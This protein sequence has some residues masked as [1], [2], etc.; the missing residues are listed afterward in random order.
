[1]NWKVLAAGAAVIVPLVGVLAM[2]FGSD[3]RAIPSMLE[4]RPAPDFAL[5]SMDGQ[6]FALDDFS[7]KPLVV[8]FWASWC[9]PC[10]QEHPWLVRTAGQYQPRGVA[11]LGVLYGD[12]V[13][14]A[15]GFLARYGNA[16]PTLLDPSQRVAIDYGVAGVP[17][18]FVIDGQGNIVK[19]FTG[20]VNPDELLATL[21]ALL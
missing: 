7:G 12:E 1:M 9:V 10:A 18:T 20:P 5:E 6:P 16:Y 21:D 8:N 14:A 11:F 3:P 4:G 2:G 17:E 15:K 19:K 13:P